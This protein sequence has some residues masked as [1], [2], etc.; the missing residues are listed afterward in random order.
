[1]NLAFC[2]PSLPGRPKTDIQVKNKL[3]PAVS[4]NLELR[5]TAA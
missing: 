5:R 3:D 1:M 4:I 2:S